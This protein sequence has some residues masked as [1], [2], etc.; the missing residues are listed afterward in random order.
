VWGDRVLESGPPVNLGTFGV[1]YVQAELSPDAAAEIEQLGYRALWISGSRGADLTVVRR[2]LDA[3][4]NLVVATGVLNIWYA[5]AH[6]VAETYHRV[7]AA[8]PARFLLGIGAGHP[9]LGADFRSPYRA[10]I[11]YLDV[12]DEYDVPKPRR[13]LAA[14]G[15][16]MLQLAAERSA[17]A[18]AYLVTPKYT[19]QA[20]DLVGPNPVLAVEHKV[21]LGQTAHTRNAG[22]HAIEVSL[23]LANYRANL[24]RMGFGERDVAQ[25]GSDA[26]IDALVAQGDA[27]T[28][29]TQLRA[30][31]DAGASHLVVHAVPNAD[32]LATLAALAPQLGLRRG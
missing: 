8:Y 27:A 32:R 7:E 31:L 11:D 20:R 12:L 24:A 18:Y 23:G 9:E 14:L 26:L 30:Q 16:R 29:A 10:M 1:H 6:A 4:E 22:R 2:I 25:G 3:T 15:P 28:A 13:L 21:A 5:E 17:G 19:R